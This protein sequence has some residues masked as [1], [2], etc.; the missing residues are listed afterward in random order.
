MAGVG[1]AYMCAYVHI[2]VLHWGDCFGV[3]A[4]RVLF[5][6]MLWGCLIALVYFDCFGAVCFGECMCDK[7][8]QA[9]KQCTHRHGE[10]VASK[11][12]R[13]GAAILAVLLW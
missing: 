10:V 7:R 1:S 4:L 9:L 6:G 3:I 11:S 12:G 8:R 2:T 5:G 13:P